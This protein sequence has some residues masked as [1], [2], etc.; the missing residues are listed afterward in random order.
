MQ[1]TIAS[2]SVSAGK[3]LFVHVNLGGKLLKRNPWSLSSVTEFPM[4]IFA[5]SQTVSR[6]IGS[7]S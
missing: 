7:P 2:V 3:T 4:T 1:S 6:A 5:S